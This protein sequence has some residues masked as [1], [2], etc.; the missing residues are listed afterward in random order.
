MSSAREDDPAQIDSGGSIAP[1]VRQPSPPPTN[2]YCIRCKKTLKTRKNFIKHKALHIQKDFLKK[3]SNCEVRERCP[4]IAKNIVKSMLDSDPVDDSRREFLQLLLQLTS[5]PA[6][7]NFV[8]M[9]CGNI[10]G[11]VYQKTNVMPQKQHERNLQ[12]LSEWLGNKSERGQLLGSMEL[13]LEGQNY[14]AS[15][16]HPVIFRFCFLMYQH[17][18][19]DYLQKASLRHG[20]SSSSQLEVFPLD[21]E[22][23]QTLFYASGSVIRFF[24]ARGKKKK[25]EEVSAVIKARTKC[26]EERLLYRQGETYSEEYLSIKAWFD[27]LDRGGLI[28]VSENFFYFLLDVEYFVRKSF[29]NQQLKYEWVIDDILKP[30]NNIL[31][32]YWGAVTNSYMTEG[33]SLLFLDSVVK[34]FVQFS[35]KAEAGLRRRVLEGTKE[36]QNVALRTCLKRN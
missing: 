22:E 19:L 27:S 4:E 3:A 13:V 23:K 5:L 32:E 10:L 33:E 35:C 12:D 25:N 2:L 18:E 24:L 28:P 15:Q 36:V 21:L 8:V 31:I 26:I 1:A 30:E 7:T 20:Q 16:V 34:R 9:A 6:W 11:I 29:F 17:L 14:S